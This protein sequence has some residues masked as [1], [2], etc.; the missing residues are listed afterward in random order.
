MIFIGIIVNILATRKTKCE[1]SSFL[2]PRENPD[3][4]CEMYLGAKLNVTK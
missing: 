4:L 1:I 2:R 3:K